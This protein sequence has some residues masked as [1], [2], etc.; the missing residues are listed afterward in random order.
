MGRSAGGIARHV[1]TITRA[2]GDDA[3]LDVAVAA[4]ADLP[5]EMPRREHDID[6]PDGPRGHRAVRRQLAD[7]VEQGRYDVV[8]GH[9]LRA[10]IDGARAAHRAGAAAVV[11]VHNLVRPEV[12]GGLRAVAYKAAEPLVVRSADRIFA[13][14][15]DIAAAL[16]RS[17]GR[18]RVEV[19]HLG[20]GE[21]PCIRRDRAEVRR[22]LHL[23][24]ERLVVAAARL[25]RQKRVDVLLEAMTL[26]DLEAVLVVAGEGPLRQELE[27]HAR[28]AGV[29]VRWMGFTP[30]V[31]DLIAAADVF[32]LSSVW[33]GIPLAAQE[34]ILLGTPVVATD[35]GGMKELITNGVTGWL[36]PPLD[37]A[38]LARALDEAL[39]DAQAAA[40]RAEAAREALARSF[41]TGTML[42]RL[43]EVY[44]AA[45]RA[46]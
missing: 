11:T 24:G 23:D 4:P 37:P 38:A 36:A 7:V 6:I 40:A 21:P 16:E 27:E 22:D 44:L 15:N 41:D 20:I 1:A 18:G 46:R 30:D 8:H 35:V 10:G 29:D 28:K 5:I 13:V 9:G 39:G 19:L 33:E 14:S 25:S 17:G 3:D 43:K 31:A 45:T 2:F 12:A 32:C 34:A 26:L 42:A